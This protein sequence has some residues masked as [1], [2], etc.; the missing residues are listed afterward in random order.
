MNP[1]ASGSSSRRPGTPSSISSCPCGSA[2]GPFGEFFAA[3]ELFLGRGFSPFLAIW[4]TFWTIGG[5]F[6]F[7]I[8]GW[9]FAGREVILVSAKWLEIRRE[10][11]AFSRSRTFDFS[12]IRNLRYSPNIPRPGFKRSGFNG[13][14]T[15][16]GS[17][18]GAIAFDV[19]T[20]PRRSPTI[21]RFGDGLPEIEARRLIK[22]IE[23][24]FKVPES[25]ELEPLPIQY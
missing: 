3:K 7:S 22:T 17:G 12:T 8:L 18:G 13:M 11:F 10:L 20:D 24:R 5:G 21:Q 23:S 14:E 19:W 15:I 9:S 4:L 25:P 1:A 16:F 2:D 6:A